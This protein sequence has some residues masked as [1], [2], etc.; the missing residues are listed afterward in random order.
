MASQWQN[1]LL[2]LGAWQGSF[3]GISPTGAVLKDTPSL[4]T[5]EAS[6]QSGDGA[7]T[8]VRFGLQRFEGGDRG[9]APSSDLSQEYR[10]L[11]RQV[12]F[13]DT[14]TFCKGSLQLA[15]GTVFGGEFGF[16]HGDR[17][18]RLVLLYGEAGS[19][20]Q[21]VLIREFRVGTGAQ[22]CPPLTAE[23]VQGPW[24]GTAATIA[25]DWP[26][27]DRAEA[28]VN[29]TA[30]GLAAF[31]WLPDGG[32]CRWPQQVSHRE[33]FTVEAGWLTAPDRLERLIRRYD[34]SGA[35]LSASHEVL[36]R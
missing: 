3:T 27:P 8:M 9:A 10:S 5:L 34:G 18:H 19:A 31:Q 1:F 20:D 32:Y 28:Q 24:Q 22:E 16:V 26:E 13:F 2:N 30:A 7:I 14:G 33:A 15:P 36:R 11:G 25:A 23:Q 17:R 6:E 35:W 29:F 4:L 21:L 12:V